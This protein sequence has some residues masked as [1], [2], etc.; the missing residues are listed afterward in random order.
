MMYWIVSI[1]LKF[2]SLTVLL[3]VMFQ[4]TS[5]ETNG[6]ELC[7]LLENVFDRVYLRKLTLQHLHQAGYFGIEPG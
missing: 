4:S 1:E 5:K 2:E 3:M 7:I 6:A